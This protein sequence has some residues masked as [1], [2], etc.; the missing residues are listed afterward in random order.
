MIFNRVLTSEEAR[1]VWNEVDSI[2]NADQ[3]HARAIVQSHDA[4]EQWHIE[5]DKVN[6]EWFAISQRGHVYEYR[7]GAT[8]HRGDVLQRPTSLTDGLIGP[9]QLAF[10]GK[11]LIWGQTPGS[12]RPILVEK[13]GRRS[14]LLT[15][16]HQLDPSMR[17]TLV[18]DT[19][20]GITTRLMQFNSPY[21]VLLD[22]EL[23]RTVERVHRTSFPE[24]EVL[25]PDY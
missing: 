12:F 4:I 8:Y 2:L 22:V 3:F 24:L 15:F 9:L 23:G 13:V 6:N 11:M 7:D 18:I 10:P 21:T 20:L 25:T 16:E 14:L 17:S 1:S 19:D 5:V